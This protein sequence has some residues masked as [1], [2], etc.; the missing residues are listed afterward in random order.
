MLEELLGG[1]LTWVGLLEEEDKTFLSIRL[2]WGGERFIM[3]GADSNA[4][5][6]TQ[7]TLS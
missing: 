2:P 4:L 3:G 5:E 7:P 1:G 6:V